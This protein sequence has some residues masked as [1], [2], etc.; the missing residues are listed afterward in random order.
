VLSGTGMSGITIARAIIT[1]RGPRQ[2]LQGHQGQ[3]QGQKKTRRDGVLLFLRSL[4]SLTSLSSSS[5]LVI[6]VVSAGSGSF[7]GSALFAYQ[8]NWQTVLFVGYA[9]DRLQNRLGD[10]QRADRLLFLKISY[11]FQR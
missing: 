4:L 10:L 8:I 6:R 2:G 3:H 11:A 7:A 9:D 5:L 1:G